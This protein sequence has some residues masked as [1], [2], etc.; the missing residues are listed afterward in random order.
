MIVIAVAGDGRELL[1]ILH[2]EKP[3]VILMDI[4]MPE[5]NGIE[6]T[7]YVNQMTRDIK[8]IIL[9]TY[10]EDHLIEKQ[11]KTGQTGIY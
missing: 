2:D 5:L 3:D 4:N 9:S 1:D 8:I 10:N 6:A 7:R 11:S